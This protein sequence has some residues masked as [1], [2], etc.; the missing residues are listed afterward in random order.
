MRLVAS[1]R[2]A[3]D[4]GHAALDLHALCGHVAPGADVLVRGYRFMPMPGADVPPF[5]VRRLQAGARPAAVTLLGGIDPATGDALVEDVADAVELAGR[6]AVGRAGLWMLRLSLGAR[7][8]SLHDVADEPAARDPLA[9]S[10]F[11]A[12]PSRCS[13]R[14]RATCPALPRRRGRLSEPRLAPQP[15]STWIGPPPCGRRITPSSCPVRC[16]RRRSPTRAPACRRSRSRTRTRR[17]PEAGMKT[18]G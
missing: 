11:A 2:T 6:L 12:E 3:V 16:A 15:S 14:S 18:N 4:D 13:R 1:A 7:T 9:A 5:L 10:A 8:L 17:T